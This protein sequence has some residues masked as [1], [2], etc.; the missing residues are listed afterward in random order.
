M[1]QT[2]Q[3]VPKYSFPF[4]DTVVNDNTLVTDIDPSANTDGENMVYYVFPF[5]SPKGIDNK[6]IKISSQDVF[7]KT[8]GRSNYK[9]YGQPMMMPYHVLENPSAVCWCMRVMPENAEY[10]HAF[11]NYKLHLPTVPEGE[12]D[13]AVSTLKAYITT[14]ISTNPW[15]PE[16]TDSAES[17]KSVE[18]VLEYADSMSGITTDS[19][20]NIVVPGVMAFCSA[21]RGTY[22]DMYSVRMSRSMYQEKEYGI[23]MYNFEVLSNENGLQRIAEY[24]GSPVTSTKYIETTFIN[25]LVADADDGNLPVYVHVSDEKIEYIYN[26]YIEFVKKMGPA[27]EAELEKKIDDYNIPE[28][29]LEGT[30]LVTDEF[31]AKVKELRNIQNKI[32]Y[33]SNPPDLDEFDPFFGTELASTLSDPF[34]TP[35]S[36]LTSD[37]DTS[38]EGFD[39]NAYTDSD[40]VVFMDDVSGASLSKGSD[41]YFTNP[42]TEEIQDPI[43]LTT[44]TKQ[45]TYEDEVENCYKKA[46]SG[47]LDKR[48][49]S[50]KRIKAHAFFDANYPMSVKNIIADLV[51]NLRKDCVFYADTGLR[52]SISTAEAQSM[53]EDFANFQDCKLSK[54]IHC[55]MVKEPN[56][57]K[58]VLVTITYLLASQFCEHIIANGVHIPFVNEYCRLTGHIKNSLYPT[59][60]DYDSDL[61]EFLVQN[62]FNYFET[63]D[64]NVYQR[65]TQ[66][67]SEPYTSDLLEENNVHIMLEMK[68]GIERIIASSLYNFADYEERMRLR[69]TVQDKYRGWN[70]SRVQSFDITFKSNKFEQERSIIHAYLEIIFRPLGKRAILEI[71]INPREYYDEEE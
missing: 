69:D 60:D 38:V 62:R 56:S 35:V 58:R 67:T 46:W 49:L 53:V 64:D 70:N 15:N 21:G 29:M 3:I 6:F 9:K 13:V 14:E 5:T 1:P 23:R 36:L 68:N 66:N 54:N 43:T 44:T 32:N 10:S 25:D 8:Y 52:K 57:M 16:N 59:I 4:V 30:V 51:V 22:G 17:P 12:T 39:A 11:I 33:C 63:M 71:D 20:G 31:A 45:W 48:I 55:Y 2:T 18:S 7:T 61:K 50:A 34:L 24:V 19:D 26:K 40:S 27:L 47:D 28:G 41:G 37:I 65:A 42:R